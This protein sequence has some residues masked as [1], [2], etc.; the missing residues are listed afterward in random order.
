MAKALICVKL[1]NCWVL[2]EYW[3]NAFDVERYVK[4]EYSAVTEEECVTVQDQKC[5]IKYD[6]VQVKLFFNHDDDDDDYDDDDDDDG[7]T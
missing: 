6:T 7:G 4:V 2:E 5:E 1:E 3:R